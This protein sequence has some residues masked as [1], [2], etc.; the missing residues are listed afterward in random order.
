MGEV[1][2]KWCL[3]VAWWSYITPHKFT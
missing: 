2:V 1:D 3:G